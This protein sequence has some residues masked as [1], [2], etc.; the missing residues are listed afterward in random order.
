VIEVHPNSIAVRAP[1]RYKPVLASIP[2]AQWSKSRYAWVY[3]LSPIVAEELF[4]RIPELRN[5]DLRDLLRIRELQR[6]SSGLDRPLPLPTPTEPWRHQREA[7]WYAEPLPA[8]LLWVEMGGGKSR[9]AIDLICSQRPPLTLICC[10]KAVIPVWREQLHRHAVEPVHLVDLQAGSVRRKAEDLGRALEDVRIGAPIVAVVNYEAVWREPLASRLLDCARDGDLR[11]I[12]ADEVHRIKSAGGRA[13][14][15]LH[16]LGSLVPK[17]LGL[18]GT[19]CPHSPLDAFGVF[20]F[21]DAGIF[22]TNFTRFRSRYAVVEQQATRGGAKFPLIFG[23][24]NEDDYARRFHSITYRARREDL[25]D[26]PAVQHHRLEVELPAAARRVYRE[27]KDEFVAEVEAGVIT[28]QN[29]AV[30]ALRLQQITSGF[31]A[32]GDEAEPIQQE[33]H[34]EKT[35]ALAELLS[36]LPPSEPVV[37]F[38]RFRR[39]LDQVHAACEKVRRGS[40]EL[41]GR[42]NHLGRWQRGEATVLATQ[43]QAGAE[44]IDLTRAAYAVYYSLGYSLGQYE[45]S[46]ARLHRPGQDRP[47]H[48]Y[49]LIATATIDTHVYRALERRKDVL[50]YLLESFR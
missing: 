37:V 32:G 1:I 47:V 6:R 30:K 15:Y 8:A 27:L 50:T 33:L 22:G 26:L 18:S 49:H 11:F 35:N 34:A 45:Q 17:R 19:P 16:R 2:G 21:L 14:R 41:S 40:L 46:L 43:I 5:G 20:R 10:P 12:V 28:A 42:C 44:G 7:Y 29:A 31:I 39:D 24:Q 36:D 13:S 4:H 23:W 9:I 48:Y 38:C 3:P 25:I